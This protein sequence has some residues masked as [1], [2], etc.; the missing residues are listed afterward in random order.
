MIFWVRVQLYKTLFFLYHTY[1][2]H[3]HVSYLGTWLRTRATMASS[4]FVLCCNLDKGDNK[5]L[6][7]GNTLSGRRNSRAWQAANNSIARHCKQWINWLLSL[8][9]D[10]ILLIKKS[11]YIHW[12]ECLISLQARPRVNITRLPFVCL[13]C[14]TVCLYAC[15][16]VC[17]SV[18]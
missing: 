16:C 11:T 6:F 3:F 13:P 8:T 9:N 15:L 12:N 18:S 2:N 17:V 7:A 10:K 14:L 1:I 5:L 4:G